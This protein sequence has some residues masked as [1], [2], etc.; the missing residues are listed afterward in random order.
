M[1][2]AEGGVPRK[3]KDPTGSFQHYK[4]QIFLPSRRRERENKRNKNASYQ[5]RQNIFEL[6]LN[7]RRRQKCTAA[8]LQFT[9]TASKPNQDK[10]LSDSLLIKAK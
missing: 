10:N 9:V 1:R 3:K 7:Y 5:L 4:L 2:V 8:T 6:L